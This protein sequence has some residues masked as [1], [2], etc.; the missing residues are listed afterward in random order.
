M[1]YL[2]MPQRLAQVD[3]LA[4]LP[5]PVLRDLAERGTTMTHPA[6]QVVVRQG[7]SNDVG[8]RLVLE[9]SAHVDVNGVARPD[10]G[11]GS[12]FGDI[13]LLDAAPRS[14]TVTAGE[15]GLKTFALSALAFAPVI[16]A[17][18]EVARVLLRALCARLRAV[19]AR[20]DAP[21]GS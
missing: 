21:V 11:P 8:L 2:S 10:L 19:E 17:N 18:P 7:D 16:D 3:L 15:D 6:G 20:V 12:W 5:E 9:G 1:S 4:G 14:A 13:S